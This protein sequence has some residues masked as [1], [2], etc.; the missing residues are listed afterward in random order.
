MVLRFGNGDCSRLWWFGE[1]GGKGRER[2]VDDDWSCGETVGLRIFG[3]P[4]GGGGECGGCETV[5]TGVSSRAAKGLVGER[6]RTFCGL[7]SSSSRVRSFACHVAIAN[8][9]AART[10]R[11]R[12]ISKIAR[13]PLPIPRKVDSQ[14]IHLIPSHRSSTFNLFP[15]FMSLH[16]ILIRTFSPFQITGTISRR[17]PNRF[18]FMSITSC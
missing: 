4:G 8:G 12:S 1:S 17:S 9:M 6:R 3:C 16:T 13:Q 15:R 5:K 7:S 10:K 11:A 14:R 2:S 18:K